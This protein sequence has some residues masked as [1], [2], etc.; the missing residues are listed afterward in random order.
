MSEH[1]EIL[2]QARE[3]LTHCDEI[4]ARF[5]ADE[6]EDWRAMARDA[7]PPMLQ[8]RQQA[9]SYLHHSDPHIRCVAL[10]VLSRIW[11]ADAQQLTKECER[12]FSNDPDNDVRGVALAILGRIYSGTNDREFGKRM[13]AIV[14]NASHPI[15]RRQLAYVNL[16]DIRGLPLE[17]WPLDD[18]FTEEMIDRRFVNSFL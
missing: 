6:M 4:I 5:E 8:S 3:D 18:D 15:S 11:K 16:F 13:A 10:R 14:S 17:N 12:L 1:E 2:R 7:L 9:E